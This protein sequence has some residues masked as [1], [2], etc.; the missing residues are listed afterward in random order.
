LA[1]LHEIRSI[2]TEGA[3]AG[4]ARLTVT[5]ATAVIVGV[6]ASPLDVDEVGG[7]DMDTIRGEIILDAWIRL[8]DV[9]TLATHI[10]VV[11][12]GATGSDGG[13]RADVETVGTILEGSAKLVGVDR[14]IQALQVGSDIDG[15]ILFDW[16]RVTIVGRI[17]VPGIVVIRG[18]IVAQSQHAVNKVAA[19]AGVDFDALRGG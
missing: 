10:Q 3:L 2:G 16:A 11:D 9:T 18:D 5:T 6:G 13:T 17:D 7:L 12:L 19:V 15:R 1:Q 4:V 8:D 14:E